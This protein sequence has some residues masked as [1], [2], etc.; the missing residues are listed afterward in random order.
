MCKDCDVYFAYKKAHMLNGIPFNAD[1]II[2]SLTYLDSLSDR[3]DDWRFNEEW[4][5][6]VTGGNASSAS[7][8]QLDHEGVWIH[9]LEHAFSEAY[10]EPTSVGPDGT[11]E[12]PC[13]K[14]CEYQ[15]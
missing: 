4:T 13:G 2:N 7:V 8:W 3:K 5:W 12:H 9:Y 10:G 6:I 1:F 14:V 11:P 15:K